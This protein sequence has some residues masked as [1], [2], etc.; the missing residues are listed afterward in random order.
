MAKELGC[1]SGC[2]SLKD[3]E[4]V[5]TLGTGSCMLFMS[6]IDVAFCEMASSEPIDSSSRLIGKILGTFARVWLVR[7][8]NPTEQ[9]RDK[10]YALKV[11]RKVEGKLDSEGRVNRGP[12]Y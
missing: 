11:L 10:V 7:S 6:C 4:L 3:F 8:A 2:L 12:F 5:R 9:D 1:K